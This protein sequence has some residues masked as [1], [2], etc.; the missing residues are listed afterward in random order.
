MQVYHIHDHFGKI[1]DPLCQ[2]L[3]AAE[4]SKIMSPQSIAARSH[5]DSDSAIDR[6]L[7]DYDRV[8]H[9]FQQRMDALGAITKFVY[10][11]RRFA[12]SYSH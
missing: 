12:L 7:S 10:F 11:C 6:L 2:T 3:A 1:T 8:L 9:R 5:E 4:V